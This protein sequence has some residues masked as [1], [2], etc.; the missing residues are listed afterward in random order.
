MTVIDHLPKTW[1][2]QLARE[3]LVDQ[4]STAIR[5]AYHR[6]QFDCYPFTPGECE[7]HL[8]EGE[9]DR[10]RAYLEWGK[11][12]DKRLDEEAEWLSDCEHLDARRQIAKRRHLLRAARE[13]QREE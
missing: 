1:R 3:A 4:L 2:Q 12:E 13:H 7:Q 10:V 8:E 9:E 11:E 6:S 5:E